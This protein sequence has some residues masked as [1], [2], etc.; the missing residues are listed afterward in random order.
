MLGRIRCL[1]KY[2]S[3][4]LEG[5]MFNELF[6][7]HKYNSGINIHILLHKDA[8]FNG[9]GVGFTTVSYEFDS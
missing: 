9:Y 7:S 4:H 2:Y 3:G 6:H 8:W 5:R 1:A